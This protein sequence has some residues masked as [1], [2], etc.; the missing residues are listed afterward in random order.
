[1]SHSRVVSAYLL[2]L[3]SPFIIVPAYV[4]LFFIIIIII[5][6]SLTAPQPALRSAATLLFD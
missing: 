6:I 2:L 1:M 4:L 3:L 5:F